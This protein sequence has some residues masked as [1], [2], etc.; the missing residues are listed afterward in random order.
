MSADG[1]A[2]FQGLRGEL[3]LDSIEGALLRA[4]VVDGAV[5]ARRIRARAVE[6]VVARGDVELLGAMPLGAR[7]ALRAPAGKGRVVVERTVMSLILEAGSGLRAPALLLRGQPPQARS[8][9]LERPGSAR[10]IDAR[11]GGTLELVETGP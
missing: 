5:T 2:G 10:L 3:E 11:V 1:G 9:R 4:S 7:W 8:L 6:I